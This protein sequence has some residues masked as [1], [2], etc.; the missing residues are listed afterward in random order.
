MPYYLML[1]CVCSMA[2]L[3]IR[4]LSVQMP[5]ELRCALSKFVIQ[6]CF[7]HNFSNSIQRDSFGVFKY[8]G[9]DDRNRNVILHFVNAF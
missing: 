4:L 7:L 9:L 6:I 1:S 8:R 5:L 2:R 3:S